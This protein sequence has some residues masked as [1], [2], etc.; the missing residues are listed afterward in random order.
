MIRGGL[1]V[2]KEKRKRKK[3][4]RGHGDR[5]GAALQRSG[6][7]FVPQYV[8]YRHE[9]ILCVLHHHI[10]R[11]LLL[12]ICFLLTII[13]T[14]KKKCIDTNTFFVSPTTMSRAHSSWAFFFL[15]TP[16]VHFF[17]CTLLLGIC[18]LLTIIVT[19]RNKIESILLHPHYPTSY[20]VIS[21]YVIVF[22]PSVCSVAL[23]FFYYRMCSLSI[24][25]VRFL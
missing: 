12:S 19:R 18:F 16:P 2:V 3:T 7:R 1:A 10:P 4:S 23:A 14:R 8:V 13:V 20:H 24:E 11:T 9:H 25:C 6:T 22:R 17:F 5:S 21:N 15:H